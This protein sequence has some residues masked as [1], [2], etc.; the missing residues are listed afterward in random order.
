MVA[1]IT[2]IM[3][4]SNHARVTVILYRTVISMALFAACGYIMGMVYEKNLLPYCKNLLKDDEV[5]AKLDIQS[6]P[7]EDTM[8]DTESE[9]DDVKEAEDFAPFTADNLRHVKPPE[10]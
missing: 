10:Q 1:I 9:S 2:I 5:G 4:F 3:G 6:S 8:A 7:Q